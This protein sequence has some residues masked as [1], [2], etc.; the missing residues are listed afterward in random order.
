MCWLWQEWGGGGCGVLRICDTLRAADQ[1]PLKPRMGRYWSFRPSASV[2]V[3]CSYSGWSGAG[4]FCQPS[5][6]CAWI[7]VAAIG[8]DPV[9]D[10]AGDGATDTSHNTPLEA[11]RSVAAVRA[12]PAI[13]RSFLFVNSNILMLSS[14]SLTTQQKAVMMVV[15]VKR[16]CRRRW[17]CRRSRRRHR[18]RHRRHCRRS[19]WRCC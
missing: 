5:L 13:T 15:R 3:R 17:R 11:N 9:G 19:C 1:E 12:G 7:A 4:H 8:C 14:L 18:S 10:D 16:W 6:D 2:P